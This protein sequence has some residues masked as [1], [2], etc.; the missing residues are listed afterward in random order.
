MAI[1][2]LEQLLQS[3]TRWVF[4]PVWLTLPRLLKISARFLRV[5]LNFYV[6][7]WPFIHCLYFIYAR[8]FY[9]RSQGKI[10]RLW[11]STPWEACSVTAFLKA[12]ILWFLLMF[13]SSLQQLFSY[14]L[15]LSLALMLLLIQ[16]QE[17]LP[18][19]LD[20]T[21][22]AWLGLPEW[23]FCKWPMG[24]L[25]MKAETGFGKVWSCLPVL[26]NWNGTLSFLSPSLHPCISDSKINRSTN[27]LINSSFCLYLFVSKQ[28]RLW[29]SAWS[30][31]RVCVR[32]FVVMWTWG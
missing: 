15:S 30:V 9:L 22:L 2:F 27:L 20:W 23:S 10:T 24:I 11:K 5:R 4:S 26:A 6:Y 3:F 19:G 17:R 7:A 18:T 16:F 12:V 25:R 29:S 28:T 14:S 13:L 8:K 1:Q 21:G 31:Y 32:C